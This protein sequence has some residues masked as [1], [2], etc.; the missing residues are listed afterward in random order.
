ADAAS[1]LADEAQLRMLRAQLEPHMLFNTLAT[2]HVLI[3]IDAPRAQSMLDQLVKFLRATLSASRSDQIKLGREFD[4]IESYLRL[5]AVRMGER[6]T[7]QLELPGSLDQAGIPPM[8]IQ[9]LVEN[10]V[11]HGLEP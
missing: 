11:R 3:G 7:F 5:M 9:P 1:R 4:L 10:A 8:L 2:L 6:L